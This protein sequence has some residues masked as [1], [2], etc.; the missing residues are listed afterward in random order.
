[1]PFDTISLK[2]CCGYI[3][4]DVKCLGEWEDSDQRILRYCGGLFIPDASGEGVICRKCKRK[5]QEIRFNCPFCYRVTN[6]GVQYR[7]KANTGRAVYMQM[8]VHKTVV[9]FN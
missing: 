7:V 3:K 1:M 6:I 9:F 4:H 8:S 5:T 2:C